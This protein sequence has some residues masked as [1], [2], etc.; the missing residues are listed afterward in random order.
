LEVLHNP[1]LPAFQQVDP[2]RPRQPFLLHLGGTWYKNRLAVLAIFERLARQPGFAELRLEIVGPPDAACETWLD[3]RPALARRI[4]RRQGLGAQEIVDLYETAA[5]LLFPS[6]AEGF[7]WPVLEALACGC[8][9]VTTRLAPMTEVA[10][11]AATYLEPAP[12]GREPDPAWV[13]RAAVQIAALLRRR[14]D[15]RHEAQRL[16]LARLAEFALDPYLDRLEARYREV[17]ALGSRR[18]A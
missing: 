17:V 18:A 2:H 13:E 9:V 12:L 6:I 14:P 10:G 4:R 3:S 11:D 15:E 7:G 5:A 1:L 16:G 8:P